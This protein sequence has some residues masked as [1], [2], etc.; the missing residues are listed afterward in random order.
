LLSASPISVRHSETEERNAVANDDCKKS[1]PIGWVIGLALYL[2]VA[3]LISGFALYSLWSTQPRVVSPSAN[4][5]K[6]DARCT[7]SDTQA[8]PKAL[9]NL[10]PDA[11]PVASASE[12]RLVGCGMGAQTQVKF[13]GQKHAA[14]FDGS[15]LIR[16]SLTSAD[17]AS[18][19]QYSI[20]I[21]DGDT[22]PAWGTGILTVDTPV[23]KWQ[24]LGFTLADLSSETTLLLL[25]IF[26]GALGSSVYALKSL[27]DYKGE[28][29]L[30]KPWITFYLIQPWEGSGVAILTYLVVRG[31]FLAG[32]SGDLKSVNQFGLCAIAGLAGAFSDIAIMKLREVFVT[33]FK[34]DD[35][36]SSKVDD[37]TIATDCLPDGDTSAN[38]SLV[39]TAKN[40]VAPYTWTVAPQPPGLNL[41]KDTGIISGKPTSVQAATNY[42][43]TVT[44]SSTPQA[45]ATKTLPLSIPK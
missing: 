31:G 25:V 39:L 41:D 7:P 6:V 42:T 43:F 29:S 8:K 35:S 45:T 40:G 27:A 5:A 44:D 14:L 22:E 37:L 26:M 36:R 30:Y 38:Y 21:S 34:P 13:N 24:V 9:T 2:I 16:L 28:E 3:T 15:G 17:T 19:G 1:M 33:L 18:A 23:S 20:A 10:F 11:V 4:S 32:N 12:V